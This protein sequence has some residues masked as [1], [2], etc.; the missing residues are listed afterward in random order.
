[1]LK[2]GLIR[3][4]AGFAMRHELAGNERHPGHTI[5]SIVLARQPILDRR[6]SV[7]GYALHYRPLTPSGQLAGPET[8]IASVMVGAMAEI[9]LEKLVGDRPAYIEVTP[10]FVRSVGQLPLPPERVVLE[11]AATPHADAALLDALHDVGK[12]GFQIAIVGVIQAGA[13]EA[14]WKLASAVKLD[15]RAVAGG[16][17]EVNDLLA[18]LRRHG[19]RLIAERVETPEQYEA[20][21]AL[22]FDAYQG[23]Y[24]AAPGSIREVVAPTHRLGALMSLT[25]A[26]TG[27]SLEDLERHICE[28]PGLSYRFVRLANSAFYAG[29]TPVGSIRQALMRLGSAA[30]SRWIMLFAL[31]KM[32]DRPQHLLNTAVHRARLCELLAHEYPDTVPERAFSAGLFSVLDAL[33]GRPMRELITDLNLDDRLAGAITDHRGPEGRLLATVM[34]YERG[35]FAA[36]AECGVRL[37]NVANGYWHAAEW[38]DYATAMVA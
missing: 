4:D 10:Q 19:L 28:D 12:A 11:L 34:A 6:E 20:T 9:G 17:D 7:V 1:M 29:R 2:D 31:S 16:G 30:V 37:V 27:A 13:G 15:A 35:D 26:T 3:A 32:T 36:C 33:L 38:A 23:Q 21:R 18:R 14:L 25:H 5:D 22:E 24:F 8:A